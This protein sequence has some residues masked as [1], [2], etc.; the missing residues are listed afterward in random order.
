VVTPGRGQ[1]AGYGRRGATGIVTTDDSRIYQEQGDSG[2]GSDAD[3]GTSIVASA[4]GRS[5]AEW[6]SGT[7]ALRELVR[8]QY[9]VQSTGIG[10][11]DWVLF[12]MLAPVWF[13]TVKV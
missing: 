9:T 7:A 13:D 4:T 12:R 11:T 6:T 5:T 3:G 1:P 8:Y 10:A 2:D